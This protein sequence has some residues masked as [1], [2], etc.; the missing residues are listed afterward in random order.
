[1]AM[2]QQSAVIC[3]WPLTCSVLK[4]R[5]TLKISKS[6]H[7]RIFIWKWR[8]RNFAERNVSV[9][10]TGGRNVR[11]SV[12]ACLSIYTWLIDRHIAVADNW[13]SIFF[14]QQ[15]R[16]LY[17]MH[18]V[19]AMDKIIP[20]WQLLPWVTSSADL[21]SHHWLMLLSGGV[22]GYHWKNIPYIF[23]RFRLLYS[24]MWRHSVLVHSICSN[25]GESRFF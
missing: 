18:E 22:N 2:F 21:L 20:P 1:M 3:C 9:N 11:N 25:N 8:Q 4:I 12:H 10:H 19:A 16:L 7:F 24:G 13:M 6:C 15:T 5:C 14:L 17:Q 23:N